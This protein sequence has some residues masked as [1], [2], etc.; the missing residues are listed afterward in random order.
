MIK[1]KFKKISSKVNC[2][3]ENRLYNFS[4]KFNNDRVLKERLWK[5]IAT[6]FC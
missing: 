1:K 3:S 2:K 6:K 5:K 4:L